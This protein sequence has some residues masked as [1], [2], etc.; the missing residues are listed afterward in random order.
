MGSGHQECVDV[1]RRAETDEGEVLPGRIARRREV[2]VV[3]LGMLGPGPPDDRTRGIQGEEITPP[4]SVAVPEPFSA[5]S[6]GQRAFQDSSHHDPAR[7]VEPDD[8][9]GASPDDLAYGGVVPVND[10][11]FRGR[12]AS[13]SARN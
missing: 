8:G 2:A 6:S 4:F 11:A 13:V 12:A 1:V 3:V 9:I 7:K 10:P 5:N